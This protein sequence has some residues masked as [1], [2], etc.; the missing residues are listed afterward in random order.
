MKY[1]LVILLGFLFMAGCSEKKETGMN[2]NASLVTREVD[3]SV[4]G[5]AFKGFLAY[6]SSIAGKKPGIIVVHEWWG[7]NQYVRERAEMLAELGY[8]ALALDMYGNGATAD[9]PDDAGKFA[10]AVMQKMDTAKARFDAGLKVLKDQPQ[11]DTSKIAAI[12]YCFGGGIVLRLAIDGIPLKGV[13]SFHG[14]LPT[15]VVKNPDMIKA[16]MLVCNG[17]DDPFNPPDKAKAFKNAMDSAKVPYKFVDYPGARH[18][19][20]NPAADSLGKKFNMS[21]LAYNKDADEKSWNEMKE[22]FNSI[23][24]K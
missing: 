22:F 18:S 17:A 1:S 3:Y 9:H 15:D 20:T 8:V 10:M 23:F 4:D 6:D 14:D 16:K 12:G 11:T 2:P 21:A 24:N 5:T 13:V 7:L 19:F